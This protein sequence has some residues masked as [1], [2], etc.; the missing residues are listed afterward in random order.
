MFASVTYPFSFLVDLDPV[1]DPVWCYLEY[2]YKWITTQI[3]KTFDDHKERLMAL[4]VIAH[5]SS[6]ST[7]SLD[8]DDCDDVGSDTRR[9]S[10]YIAPSILSGLTEK[11]VVHFSEPMDLG[12]LKNAISC[13]YS[14]E[15]EA[16]FGMFDFVLSE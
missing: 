9:S 8:A 1:G 11:N 12:L 7:E 3:L 16:L 14:S 5:S 13:L 6:N 4:L 15:F 10:T 2:Q